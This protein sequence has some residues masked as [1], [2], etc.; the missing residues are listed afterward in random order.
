MT[1]VKERKMRSFMKNLVPMKVSGPK[2]I[3]NDR[4]V[5]WRQATVIGDD[6][7]ESLVEIS[8]TKH[9][10]FIVSY[11]SGSLRFQ[12]IEMYRA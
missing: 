2:L 11:N 7:D 12:I 10:M 8:K 3:E 4:K 6:L 1:L 9:K 5:I